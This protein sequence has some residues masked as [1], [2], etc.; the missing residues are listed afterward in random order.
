[1]RHLGRSEPLIHS[2]GAGQG[3][4]GNIV[5]R[6]NDE[7]IREISAVYTD[8]KEDKITRGQ[9]DYKRKTILEDLKRR[10]GSF[11]KLVFNGKTANQGLRIKRKLSIPA[12]RDIDQYAD[13]LTKLS[14]YAK[15]GGVILA[16]AGAVMA[17]KAIGDTDD[18]QEKNEILVGTVTGTLVSGAAG[19]AVG[20]FLVSNPAGWAVALV[21]GV[22]TVTASYG[23]G[24]AAGKV[25]DLKFKE[26]DFVEMS[27]I[28][29]LCQ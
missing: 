15:G 10:I 27:G 6:G 26:Y 7:I 12:T 22:G 5:G 19:F 11:D 8:F 25:Y 23:A 28:D 29:K 21:L 18:R 16:G 17:C 9:Y 24:K 20:I 13:K 14:K 2:S 4:F 1:M 3:A